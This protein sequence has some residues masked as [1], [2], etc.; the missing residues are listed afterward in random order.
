MTRFRLII[1]IHF[2]SFRIDFNKNRGS[3][4]ILTIVILFQTTYITWSN[5]KYALLLHLL[6]K[7]HKEILV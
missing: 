7:C 5:L 2:V 4:K 6:A 1:L 3:Y